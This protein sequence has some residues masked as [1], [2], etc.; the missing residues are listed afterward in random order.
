MALRDVAL[1]DGE[2][3]RKA[4]LRGQEVVVGEV[5]SPRP[6]GVGHAIADREELTLAVVEESE[7]H[8][9]RQGRCATGNVGQA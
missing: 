7:V 3:A 6:A 9:V 2:E 1:G 5:R 8:P 4:R